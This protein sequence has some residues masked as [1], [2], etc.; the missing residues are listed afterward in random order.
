MT[1]SIEEE[2][3][4]IILSKY[5]SVRDFALS[6]DIP[7]STL[8]SIFKRGVDKANITSIIKICSELGLSVD[9]L[10]NGKL[11]FKDNCGAD[12]HEIP[13]KLLDKYSGPNQPDRYIA[14][15][16]GG[17][18]SAENAK[19]IEDLILDLK[20]QLVKQIYACE[21]NVAQLRQLQ[22]IIRALERY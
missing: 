18:V 14:A 19:E 1:L 11:S 17:I 21:L 2:L 4:N 20:D 6:C 22:D 9:A 3:K 8:D 15:Y 10:A 5:K 12:E 13:S 16:G 7:Y